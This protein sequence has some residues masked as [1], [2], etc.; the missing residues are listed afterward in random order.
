MVWWAAFLWQC[1]HPMG[2]GD[3]IFVIYMYHCAKSSIALI[4]DK[5][6]G[7]LFVLGLVQCVPSA[8]DQSSKE[9]KYVSCY[10]SHCLK[11]VQVQ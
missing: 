11:G 10:M 2:N 4:E 6:A 9:S 7:L 3:V 1:Y 5:I 8:M